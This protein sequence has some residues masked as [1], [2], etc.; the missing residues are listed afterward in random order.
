MYEPWVD[1]EHHK[2]K[3]FFKILYEHNFVIEVIF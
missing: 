3:V 1:P 2:I